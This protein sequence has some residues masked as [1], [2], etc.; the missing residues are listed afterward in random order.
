MIKGITII[1][2]SVILCFTL[3][4][5]LYTGCSQV[6]TEDPIPD[7]PREKP[8]AISETNE[9]P[10]TTISE[11]ARAVFMEARKMTEHLRTDEARE[12]FNKAIKLDPG[13]ALA[14][15][16][17]AGD[18][19]SDEDLKNNLNKAISLIDN[20]SEGEQLLIKQRKA[21]IID[22]DLDRQFEL[23][24]LLVQ[25]Y[26]DDK[27]VRN[28]LG[29][30]HRSRDE[31][32]MAIAQFE[33]AIVIDKNYPPPYNNLGYACREIGEYEK[34]EQA[35][36][37]Y[38]SLIP[39]EPN[40]YDSMGDLYM[41]LG[42]FT[43]A[44]DQYQTAI[45][46][47]SAFGISQQKIG[48]SLIFLGQYDDGR[49]AC[50][51]AVDMELTEW[52][53]LSDRDMIVRSYL[54]EGDYMKALAAA[55]EL[56]KA[57]IAAG[58]PTW[59]PYTHIIR[60]KI[61]F[62]AGNLDAAA[63]CVSDYYQSVETS[64]FTP[65]TV[66]YFDRTINAFEARLAARQQDSETAFKKAEDYK[67]LLVARND[68]NTEKKYNGLAGLLYLDTGNLQKAIE[69]FKLSD[70]ENPYILYFYGVVLT[71][72]GDHGNASKSYTKSA[73]WNEDSYDYAFVRAKAFAAIS[74]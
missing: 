8:I 5:A 6:Q 37:N 44:I 14:Y 73:N 7:Q 29:I 32:I 46:L 42:R 68:P 36:K 26:P 74:E 22:N 58:L 25:N 60:G 41:K 2:Q 50:L 1:S 23:R 66:N 65:A 4:I 24:K 47:D 69:H 43:E 38:I 30:S 64:N 27:R 10:V 13:F 17:R 56:L 20:V 11:E 9:V 40:P 34:A 67:A 39:D 18:Y 52:D 55:D 21:Y 16:Y 3:V 71:E 12:Y 54:Y 63:Q 62:E 31:D 51:K 33:S 15:L 28:L 61:N 59:A 45:G 57:G 48:T 72:T 53:K 19:I 35:F 49:E 70:Q